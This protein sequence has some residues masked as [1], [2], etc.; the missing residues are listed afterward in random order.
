MV[1]VAYRVWQKLEVDKFVVT[2]P[3]VYQYMIIKYHMHTYVIGTG[4]YMC[5]YHL[6]VHGT[7]NPMS[8]VI[9][10]DMI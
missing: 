5:T 4:I 2:I 9:F 7:D 6:L 10:L 3:N 1:Y 8:V